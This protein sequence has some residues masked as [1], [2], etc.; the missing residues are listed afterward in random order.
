M[1]IYSEY[2]VYKLLY[3]Q[4][5]SQRILSKILELVEICHVGTLE[6][7]EIEAVPNIE[8]ILII[9]ALLSPRGPSGEILKFL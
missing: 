5:G 8:F 4:G 6:K 7:A 2:V 1:A 3:A 9:I